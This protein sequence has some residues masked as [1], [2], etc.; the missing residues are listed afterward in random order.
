MNIERRNK[1]EQLRKEGKT[2]PEICEI[3]NIGK[4]TVGYYLKDFNRKI[5]NY[6]NEKQKQDIKYLIS[7]RSTRKEISKILKI[8]I[9]LINNFLDSSNIKKPKE[10]SK[11]KSRRK[12]LNVINWKKEKKKLL[13]EYKGGKCERCGY[14]KCIAALEFHHKN[15][16]EKDFSISTNSLSFEK[17]K[18]EVDKCELLCANCH[19]EVHYFPQNFSI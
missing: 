3:L 10:D 17:M 1:I 6:L 13:V 4:G 12:S 19:R 18:L 15:P 2:I 11:S 14:D 16:K 9:K 8:E 5:K 7:Q